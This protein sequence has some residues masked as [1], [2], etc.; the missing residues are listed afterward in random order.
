MIV[1][2]LDWFDQARG[3][4]ANTARSMLVFSF[5]QEVV[6]GLEYKDLRERVERRVKHTLDSAAM[7]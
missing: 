2:W 3:I 4:D 6:Q 7:N 5:G 1:G